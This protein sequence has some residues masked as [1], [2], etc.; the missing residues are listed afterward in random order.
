VCL[1]S[2][3]EQFLRVDYNI[4]FE[5]EAAKL[6]DFGGNEKGCRFTVRAKLGCESVFYVRPFESPAREYPGVVDK[7]ELQALFAA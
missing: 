2:T 6:Q 1:G 5:G 3:E 4:Y 7:G